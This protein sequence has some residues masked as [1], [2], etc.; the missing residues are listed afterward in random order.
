MDFSRYSDPEVLRFADEVRAVIEPFCTTKRR[1]LH[2]ETRDEFDAELHRTLG[3][4]G[5]I[6]STWPAE[7]G[8]AGL[9]RGRAVTLELE[10]ARADV[11]RI[12]LS[13]SRMVC[14]AVHRF[15]RGTFRDDV[16]REVAAGREVL[17]LGY[18]E[19]ESGSDIASAQTRAVRDG[20]AWIVDGQKMYTTGAHHAK[21][22]FLLARTDPAVDKHRGLTMFLVPLDSPGVAIHSIPTLGER[23]N[24]VYFTGV[25]VPDTHRLGDPG[26]GWTVLMGPLNEEHGLGDSRALTDVAIHNSRRL[27]TAFLAFRAWA[28]EP[29]ANGDRPIDDEQVRRALADCVVDLSAYS[30]TWGLTGRVAASESFQDRV[31]DL[32]EL[33]GVE[34]LLTGMAG[35]ERHAGL[36]EHLRR[37]SQVSTI[38]GGTVEVF[39]N[40]IAQS[41]GLPRMKFPA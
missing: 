16:V 31:G 21:W 24:A 23:T 15:A 32:V 22:V 36:V 41:L 29:D 25:R 40:M 10:L 8:G 38:Y 6:M 14:E 19:S 30:S 1:E 5:W 3:E 4:R 39:R 33:M 35:D 11:P 12:N 2:E 17:T 20:D 34:A 28:N 7:L 13:T 9:D 18:T 27:A 26:D 37:S